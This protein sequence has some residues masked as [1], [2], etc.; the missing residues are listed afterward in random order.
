MIFAIHSNV[1]PHF[2]LLSLLILPSTRAFKAADTSCNELTQPPLTVTPY[3]PGK[4]GTEARSEAES[5][6]K[7][8]V[9][10]RC[11]KV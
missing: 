1:V 9:G 10:G 7:R 2:L 8:K 3:C 4:A 11:F 6:R 5:R